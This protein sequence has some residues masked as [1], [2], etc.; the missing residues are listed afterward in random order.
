M[1]L[2]SDCGRLARGACLAACKLR[3]PRGRSSGFYNGL[4]KCGCAAP[5]ALT[6]SAVMVMMGCDGSWWLRSVS[7]GRGLHFLSRAVSRA[8]SLSYDQLQMLLRDRYN[9]L[10]G[11]GSDAISARIDLACW[12]GPKCGAF[13]RLNTPYLTSVC[14]YSL[15]GMADG[16]GH[17][18]LGASEAPAPRHP[19]AQPRSTAPQSPSTGL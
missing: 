11:L 13:R 9:D 15:R 2:R 7:S 8:C 5:W 18:E 1:T 19:A 12:L 16:T 4:Q 6:N 10:Q 17:S 3:H 14:G